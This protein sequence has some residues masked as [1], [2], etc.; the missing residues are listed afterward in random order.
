MIPMTGSKATGL[1]RTLS[2]QGQAFSIDHLLSTTPAQKPCF[3]LAASAAGEVKYDGKGTIPLFSPC[4]NMSPCFLIP[5]RR[6]RA[7]GS[8]RGG[9]GS[10]HVRGGREDGGVGVKEGEREGEDGVRGA[11]RLTTRAR[12]GGSPEATNVYG[13]HP[14]IN[15]IVTIYF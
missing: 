4:R 2:T 3:S 10:L 9:G 1:S 15:I 7:N 8:G 6:E 5:S 14:I 13:R 11:S 12:S